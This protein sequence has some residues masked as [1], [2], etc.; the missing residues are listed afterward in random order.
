MRRLT[1]RVVPWL[2]V[3]GLVLVVPAPTTAPAGGAAA[4][5]TG[6][7]S[8]P[9]IVLVLTDD[10]RFDEIDAMPVLQRELVDRGLLLTRAYVANPLCCPSRSSIFTGQYSHTTAVYSNGDNALGGGYWEFE[11]R[12]TVAVWLHDAGYRTALIGKYQNHYDRPE[13]VPPGWD[14]WVAIAG[15]NSKFYEYDLSVDGLVEHHGSGAEDYSTD[16]FA[17]EADAFIR[18]TPPARPLFLYLA[19]A[20]A[21]GPNTPPERYLHT[22]D[23]DEPPRRPNFDE[24][25]LRDKPGY[26]RL[27]PPLGDPEFRSR[28]HQWQG[29]RGTLL[30][31]DDALATILAALEETGRLE[32][33][34]IVFMSDNGL[35]LGEHRWMYKL[36]PHEESIR[37]PLVIRWDGVAAPGTTTDALVSNVDLAPTFLR[38]A[39]IPIPPTVEGVSMLPLLARGDPIRDEILVEHAHIGLRYDPPSYCALRTADWKLVHYATGEEEL[40]DLVAD[41]FELDNVAGSASEAARLDALRDRLRELCNPMPP[42]MPPF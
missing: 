14:R 3:A 29:G 4:A 27:L 33:S 24:R 39:G 19:T 40:Y 36:N 35:S 37:V 5:A 15:P 30:A 10:Q 7:G 34:L 12:A 18:G 20:A 23:G 6:A 11:D 17:R 13:L 25:D 41:P 28:A 26:L 2:L 32:H 8:R 31:V 42:E 21:H 16:L 9:D 38:A 22:F 1:A